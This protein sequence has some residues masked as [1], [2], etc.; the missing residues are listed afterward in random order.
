MWESERRPI[1]PAFFT[2]VLDGGGGRLHPSASL[3]RI[4]ANILAA[5][6]DS[7]FVQ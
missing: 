2:S 6:C 5:R 7:Y 3:I 4:Q 1:I